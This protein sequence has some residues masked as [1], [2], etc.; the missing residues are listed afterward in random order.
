MDSTNTT[1]VTFA[2]DQ[3]SEDGGLSSENY[4]EGR[5]TIRPAEGSIYLGSELVANRGDDSTGAAATLSLPLN[6]PDTN[7]ADPNSICAIGREAETAGRGAIALGRLSSAKSQY[8]VAIG[9]NAYCDTTASGDIDYVT[10]YGIAIGSTATVSSTS[11]DID[12]SNPV[13]QAYTHDQPLL[14]GGVAVG[15]STQVYATRGISMGQ[16]IVNMGPG[17]ACIG[18]YLFTN[19]PNQVVLGEYNKISED[20]VLVIGDGSSNQNKYV[21]GDYVTE[22]NSHNCVEIT[23]DTIRLTNGDNGTFD[24][25]QEIEDLKENSAICWE[26]W[27]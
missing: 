9:N 19:V 1:K 15:P 23:K 8:A 24:V 27:E 3:R 13:F 4:P 21:D 18:N 6:V 16:Y 12:Y 25:R 11:S 5:I 26:V 2:V 17:S 14:G 20:A 7:T 22:D 10:S